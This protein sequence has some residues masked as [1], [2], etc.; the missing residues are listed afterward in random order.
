MGKIHLLFWCGTRMAYFLDAYYVL[1][2]MFVALYDAM[3]T[4]S[5]QKE[6][7]D[8]LFLPKYLFMLKFMV[9][10]Q[11]SF[12]SGHLWKVNKSNALV[13]CIYSAHTTS[14]EISTLKTPKADAFLDSFEFDGNGNLLSKVTINGT[15]HSILLNKLRNPNQRKSQE[16]LALLKE[17]LNKLKHRILTNIKDNQWPMWGRDILL[18]LVSPWAVW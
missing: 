12:K 2:N 6:E 8:S 10:V 16:V 7:R 5:I 4:Q 15:S 17:S 13:S 18:L 9:D 1:E 3:F 11:K 14:L